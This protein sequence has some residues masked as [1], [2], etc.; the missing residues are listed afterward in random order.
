MSADNSLQTNYVFSL[1]ALILWKLSNLLRLLSR[2]R[3]SRHRESSTAWKIAGSMFCSTAFASTA[4]ASTVFASACFHNAAFTVPPNVRSQLLYHV[5]SG[6]TPRFLVYTILGAP[7]SFWYQKWHN[8]NP[9]CAPKNCILNLVSVETDMRNEQRFQ[10]YTNYTV[11]RRIIR[12][13]KLL[14]NVV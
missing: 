7:H 5:I 12:K 3:E 10:Q 2:Y 13:K 9:W 14:Y 4:F 8:Q 1:P 11:R 6:C